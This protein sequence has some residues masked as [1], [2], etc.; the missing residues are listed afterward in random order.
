MPIN[1]NGSLGRQDG[2]AALTRQIGE[3]NTKVS[4]LAQEVAT[5][6]GAK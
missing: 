1:G 2:L 4:A 6:R 5:L 3:L